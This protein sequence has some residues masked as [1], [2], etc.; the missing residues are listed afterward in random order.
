MLPL[1]QAFP[2]PGGPASGFGQD[3]FGSVGRAPFR[4]VLALV[5]PESLQYAG[6]PLFGVGPVFS[7]GLTVS[8]DALFSGM[9]AMCANLLH[10]SVGTKVSNCLS[11][12]PIDKNGQAVLTAAGAPDVDAQPPCFS[13]Y[14]PAMFA[15][16]AQAINTH[17]VPLRNNSMG[18]VVLED[19]PG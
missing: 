12:A 18:G 3:A 16:E 17:H 8:R 9:C 2:Y 5:S 1:R 6:G 19:Y 11:G 13:R 4:S 15:A 14:S 10:G 7:K